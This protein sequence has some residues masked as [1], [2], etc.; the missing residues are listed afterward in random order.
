[1]HRSVLVARQAIS[2]FE[3][4]KPDDGEAYWAVILKACDERVAVSR[5]LQHFIKEFG[6]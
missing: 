6:Y 4:V 3:R 5:R 2:G 1:V